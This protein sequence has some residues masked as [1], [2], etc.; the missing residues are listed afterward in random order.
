MA[1]APLT[2][3]TM[4]QVVQAAADNYGERVAIEDGD[5]SLTYTQLNAARLQVAA[6]CHAQGLVK[7]DC[8]AVWAP[9]IYNWILA[10]IGAQSM[11]LVL[12]PI[13]TRWKG[14]EAAYALNMSKAKLLFTVLVQ[15]WVGC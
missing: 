15:V 7:G 3:A 10:A 13:N 8:V 14:T 5:V 4:A 2:E 6:A 1:E 11:G 12:V 9:N